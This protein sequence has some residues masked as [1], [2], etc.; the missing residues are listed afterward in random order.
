MNMKY[1]VLLF[2]LLTFFIPLSHAQQHGKIKKIVID[3][4]HGGSDPGCIGKKSKEKDVNLSVALKLG[5]LIT[6]NCKDVQVVYTRKTDVAVKLYERAQIANNQ[7][8]DLFISIHCN[9]A[10]NKNAKGIETFV[11]GLSKS[12]ANMDVAKKE[13][14]VILKENNFENNYD[15]FDPNSPESYIVFS[16]YSSAYLKYSAMLAAKVQRNLVMNTQLTDRNVQQAEFWVLYK[17]AMPSILVE[18][19]FLSNAQEESYLIKPA[20]QD[21][22]AVSIYNAFVEYKNQMEGTN[23]PTLPVTTAVERFAG[24]TEEPASDRI[25]ETKAVKESKPEK[26]EITTEIK[27]DT[28]VANG[29]N[30]EVIRFRVQFA[31]SSKDIALTDSRFEKVKTVKKYHENNLWKFT[32]G[33]EAIYEDALALLKIVKATYPDAFLIAFSNDKKIPVSEARDLLK[34]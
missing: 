21:L 28:P 11:M 34:K 33:D 8:A 6:E 27:T 19:G 15:G 2:A 32:S 9:A 1:W 16:I 29:K 14:A 17:V 25:S 12:D 24:K 3:A 4:G 26:T 22:M 31:T 30:G 20:T 7:H 23:K 10:E 5:K 13:N 18:L